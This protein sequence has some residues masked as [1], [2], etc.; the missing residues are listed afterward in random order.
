MGTLGSNFTNSS[1]SKLSKLGS[2]SEQSEASFLLIHKILLSNFSL[3]STPYSPYSSFIISFT[4]SI[5]S[6]KLF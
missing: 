6:N 3:S 2:L 5:S 1:F 4:D